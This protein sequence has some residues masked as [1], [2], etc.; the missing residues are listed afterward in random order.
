MKRL[1]KADF[2]RLKGS[3]A[4][5]LALLGM[6]AVAAG[7]MFMQA[8]GMDY[9]VPLSR[10][11]FLPMSLYGIAMAAFVSAFVGTDFS[12]GFIRNKLL[13]TDRRASL[14]LSEI[15]VACTGCV[16]VYIVTTAF[17]AGV[18]RFF[19]ENNVTG[20]GFFKRFLL[21]LGMSLSTGCLFAIITLLC[22]NKTHAIIWCMGLA[23]GMLFLC[24][25]TNEVLVQTEFKDGVLNSHYV[26]GFRRAVCGVLHDLNPCGIAA[27]LSSWQVWHP[28]RALASSLLLIV[29][30]SALGCA[31]F[32]GKDIN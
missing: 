17:S 18:G 28:F 10:V 29:G 26:G 5:R 2:A 20:A 9:T 24:L 1:L 3:F 4:F 25:H 6:L 23:F 11:I 19:F 31:L 12:D 22:G 7:M 14:V 27:Q 8:N 16:I 15:A 21:G 13:A 30:S 32:H